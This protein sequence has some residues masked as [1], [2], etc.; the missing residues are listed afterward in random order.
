MID[1]FSLEPLPCMKEEA[2]PSSIII[3]PVCSRYREDFWGIA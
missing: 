3:P 1:N 2:E